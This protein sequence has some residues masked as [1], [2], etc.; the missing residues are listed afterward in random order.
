MFNPNKSPQQPAVHAVDPVQPQHFPTINR[1]H[2][3]ALTEKYGEI[4]AEVIRHDDTRAEH[5]PEFIPLREANL[6]DS[7]GI[8]RTYALTFLTY[9]PENDEIYAIDQELKAGGMIGATF[10]KHGYEV[11]KNVLDVF[12]VTVTPELQSYFRLDAPEAKG[13]LAEFY[14]RRGDDEPKIYGNVLEIYTP[15][16]RPATI[17][18][19][20]IV[21]VNPA[22]DVLKRH[23]IGKEDIWNHLE[24]A[25]ELDEWADR[26]SDYD[27]AKRESLPAVM[28]WRK[29]IETHLG[30]TLHSVGEYNSR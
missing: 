6:C 13:R 9:D 25:S 8:S 10:K 28:A 24:Q 27:A 21:Q 29:R 3:D 23:A 4:H 5:D 12:T 1:L 15:D 26:E 30:V 11:R 22:T 7:E 14:A 18:A 20:D 2:T 16:F 19:V 17:N